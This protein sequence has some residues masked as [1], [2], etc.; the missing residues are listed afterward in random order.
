MYKVF[1]WVSK[2]TLFEN[3]KDADMLSL[4]GYIL[5]ILNYYDGVSALLILLLQC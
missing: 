2:T 1:V 5:N 3:M 4:I